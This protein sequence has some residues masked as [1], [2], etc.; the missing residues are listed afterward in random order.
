MEQKLTFWGYIDFKN[1]NS[2]REYKFVFSPYVS[3]W[4]L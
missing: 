3:F 4:G 1:N 2:S